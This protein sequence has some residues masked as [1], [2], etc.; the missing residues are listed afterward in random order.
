MI[1]YMSDLVNIFSGYDVERSD[2]GLITELVDETKGLWDEDKS[3]GEKLLGML[4]KIANF[5]GF[6]WKMLSGTRKPLETLSE[7]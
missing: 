6:R 4:G 7:K 1:P 2:M 3:A 5:L